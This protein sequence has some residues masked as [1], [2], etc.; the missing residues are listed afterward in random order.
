MLG[1]LKYNILSHARIARHA[2]HRASCAASEESN[3]IRADVDHVERTCANIC[4]LRGMLP[5]TCFILWFGGIPQPS[6]PSRSLL[7]PC[8]NRLSVMRRACPGLKIRWKGKLLRY[9]WW[10]RTTIKCGSFPN[11]GGPNKVPRPG[12][13]PGTFR[14]SV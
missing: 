12:I 5:C 1:S 10:L 14:S 8:R 6:I 4:S 9:S 2:P 11:E 7:L 13:E 3:I